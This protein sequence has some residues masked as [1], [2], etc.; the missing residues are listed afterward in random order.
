MTATPDLG[1]LAR[2]AQA[3]QDALSAAQAEQAAQAAAATEERRQRGLAW[4][5][6]F[7]STYPGRQAAANG[8][9]TEALAAF[10]AAVTSGEAPKAYLAIAR[11]MAAANA[12]GAE[13]AK[14]RNIL[15]VAGLIQ[16]ENVG[17]RPDP[18]GVH[19]APYPPTAL[20]PYSELLGSSLDAARAAASRVPS[21]EDPGSFEGQVADDE[22][23]AVMAYEW[24]FSQDLEQLL[25]FR[26]QHPARFARNT[27]EA[28][29]AATAAYAAGR[30][31]RGYDAALP[32]MVAEGPREAA[33]P[34]AF[35]PTDTVRVR[36]YDDR[37]PPSR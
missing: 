14:A 29:K 32:K 5:F 11:A 7:I 13:Y 33:E 28:E 4:A 35:G 23:K 24:S 37:H 20:P 3:A 25:A 2:D 16:P 15:R 26:E 22:R 30:E 6:R 19:N 8:R 9:V 34:P 31:A 36:L 17:H 18:V 10:D 27:S 21:A 1:K 12:V